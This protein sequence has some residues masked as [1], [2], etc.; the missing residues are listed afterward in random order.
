MKLCDAVNEMDSSQSF[1]RQDF[2]EKVLSI[3]PEYN[4]NSLSSSIDSF[5]KKQVFMKLD[6]DNYILTSDR[7]YYSYKNSEQLKEIQNTV[8]EEY[9]DANFQAWEFSQLNEF[10]NHLLANTTYVIEVESVFLESVFE[11]LKEK[12][13]NVLFNPTSK[14]FFRYA[15]NKTIVVKKLVSE[16]PTDNEKPHQLQL[17]KLLVD[18]VVDRFTSQIIN[19]SEIYDIYNY[20]LNNYYVSENKLIRYAKRRNANTKIKYILE[21]I[22]EEKLW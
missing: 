13:D 2:K 15:K 16:A 17:E 14:E 11:T 8:H 10:L 22:Q 19:R 7:K 12:Y 18:I 6:E 20:C 1:S 5:I 4:E 3:Y 9:P 21:N